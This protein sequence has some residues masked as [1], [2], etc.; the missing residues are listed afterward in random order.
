[1][2]CTIGDISVTT[3]TELNTYTG[4]TCIE[5]SLTLRGPSITD[6]SPLS[7]LTNVAKFI[8]VAETGLSE[9]VSNAFPSLIDAGGGIF[10]N[11][12]HLLESLD[13]FHS[14]V[15]TGDNIDFWYHDNLNS[16][17][18]FESL[19][20]AGWSLEIGGN[21]LLTTIPN[22]ESLKTIKSSLFILDNDSLSK[23]TGFGALEYV[24]WSF[25]IKDDSTIGSGPMDLCGFY[26]Y[27]NNFAG[28]KYSGRGAFDVERNGVVTTVQNVI[29]A[30]PCSS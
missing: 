13:G 1:M 14:L 6:L 15:S 5:G 11:K 10:F 20:T 23:I 16:L 22:Y 27:K 29:D 25:Q 2:A 7:S 21:P 18:G 30:G 19:E 3:Q 28:G 12:N 9:S 4:I 26:A 24:D 8:S 17:T